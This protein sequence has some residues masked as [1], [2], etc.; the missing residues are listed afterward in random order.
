MRDLDGNLIELVVSRGFPVQALPAPAVTGTGVADGDYRAW[1]T[2]DEA[3]DADDTCEVL[4]SINA[5]DV[6]LDHYGFDTEW[7]VKVRRHCNRVVAIDD[8]RDRK[9]SVDVLI[10]AGPDWLVEKTHG[11]IH[12]NRSPVG[13]LELFGPLFAPM[14]RTVTRGREVARLHRSRVARILVFYGGSDN[15]GRTLEAVRALCHPDLRH[16]AVDVIHGGVCEGLPE[17]RE[18]AREHGKMDVTPMQASLVPQMLAADLMLGAGGMTALERCALRLPSLTTPI[19]ENQSS[20]AHAL[21]QIGASLLLEPDDVQGAQAARFTTQLGQAVR[22]LLASADARQQMSYA[23]EQVTDSRGA[24]RIAEIM[25][26]S[27]AAVSQLRRADGGDSTILWHWTNEASARAARHDPKWISWEEHRAWFEQQLKDPNAYIWILETSRGLPLGQFRVNL[28]GAV[29]FV[30]Y[31]IDVHFRGR[32]LGVRLIKDGLAR[33]REINP[34]IPLTAE[35]LHGNVA[36]ARTL[37][38]A[39]FSRKSDSAHALSRGGRVSIFQCSVMQNHGSSQVSP[40]S[41]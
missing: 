6:I 14:H 12:S 10:D 25:F 33:W 21:H 40:D 31:S 37:S 9:H 29:G 16:V 26:P 18:L 3:Q 39:G 30:D 24:E 4:R 15:H 7:E 36:S 20:A 27:G 28:H 34:S 19:A 5:T 2:V 13:S 1:A 22:D 38:G 23:A 8:L 41:S 17:I 32:G 35:V 11:E